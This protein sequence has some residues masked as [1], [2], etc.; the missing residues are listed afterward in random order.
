[1][2]SATSYE[3]ADRIASGRI[4]VFKGR[5]ADGVMVLMHQLT[6]GFDHSG[7]LKLGIAYIVA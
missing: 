6:P 7:V 3:L 5:R 4:A 2:A 1:M